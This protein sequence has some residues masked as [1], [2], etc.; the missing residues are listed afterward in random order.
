MKRQL[1]DAMFYQSQPSLIRRGLRPL[2]IADNGVL[3]R[4]TFP[5]ADNV[6]VGSPGAA[7]AFRRVA[8]DAVAVEK[9]IVQHQ[10]K[11]PA[12]Y[13][14]VEQP[15]CLDIEGA[16]LAKMYSEKEEDF[17]RRAACVWFAMRVAEMKAEAAYYG[18]TL[19]VGAY[20][21]LLPFAN[22]PEGKRGSEADWKILTD[23]YD[24]A[25]PDFY[26][27]SADLDDW[28]RDCDRKLAD[29]DRLIPGRPVYPMTAP[30][31]GHE[32]PAEIRFTPVPLDFY[33]KAMSLL[34]ARKDV[35]GTALWGGNK[36]N[37]NPD[38]TERLPFEVVAPYVDVLTELA[39]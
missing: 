27:R 5:E 33:R 1:F 21:P 4:A 12:S 34:F 32:A 3:N 25:Y 36:F 17:D 2:Y 15:V 7:F 20:T 30:H 18:K 19:S 22:T 29:C 37:D 24:A 6:S 26:F 16:P 38:G 31:F 11:L 13:D 39:H 28:E 10:Y 23:A 9:G 8:R 14:A 35:A